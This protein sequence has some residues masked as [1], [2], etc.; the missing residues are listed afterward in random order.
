M[1]NVVDDKNAHADDKDDDAVDGDDVDL[2][3]EV[4]NTLSFFWAA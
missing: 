2:Q 1:Q 3:I 4:N